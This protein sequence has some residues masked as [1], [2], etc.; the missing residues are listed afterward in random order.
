MLPEPLR[1][2]PCAATA[3]AAARGV[4]K[5]AAN[6]RQLGPRTAL[7]AV[8]RAGRT[9]GQPP[10]TA[11]AS[12]RAAFARAERVTSPH[13]TGW[14]RHCVAPP[15]K[16]S[17]SFAPLKCSYAAPQSHLFNLFTS[18]HGSQ[19]QECRASL[20]THLEMRFHSVGTCKP[21]VASLQAMTIS[22]GLGVAPFGR[23]RTMLR[24]LTLDG[25]FWPFVGP[26]RASFV[27]HAHP[28]LKL[29]SRW[30]IFNREIE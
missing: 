3:F 20:I 16:L 26:G 11:P 25:F 22:G 9:E 18:L 13:T 4:R 24:Q 15:A 1:L 28:A 6:R 2:A 21:V 19:R 27:E 14:T 10:C 8:S 30:S 7:T 12:T 23:S 29:P 17:D 5:C